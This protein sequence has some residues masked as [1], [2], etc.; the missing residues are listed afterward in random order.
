MQILLINY[1]LQIQNKKMS[2]NNHVP[3]IVWDLSFACN[4]SAN[5]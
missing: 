3:K 4:N 1:T 5:I 2:E